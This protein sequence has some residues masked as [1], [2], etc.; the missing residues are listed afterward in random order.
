MTGLLRT[1]PV[2]VIAI[3][4]TLPP[5]PPAPPDPEIVTAKLVVELCESYRPYVEL[6]HDDFPIDP[7]L[8]L[9]VMAQESGCWVHN[10]MQVTPTHWTTTEAR[11]RDPAVSIEFG[12]WILYNAIHNETE[13][14]DADVRRGLA[15]Y[16]CG[17][18]SLNAG[19]CLSFGGYAY[20]D[21]V[22]DF[23]LPIVQGQEPQ[24][25]GPR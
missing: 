16:N 4:G 1:L 17:W 14:P 19:K 11:L 12:M 18:A 25:A 21:K 20:A 22:L 9:A 5:G 15:A 8:V 24:A 10:V 13:N 3:W 23:W 6:M 7:D 2:L